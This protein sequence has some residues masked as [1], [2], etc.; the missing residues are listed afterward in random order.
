MRTSKYPLLPLLQLR[1]R[2]VDQAAHGL[3]E[4]V[5]VRAAAEVRLR[6]A[7]AAEV[8]ARCAAQT[9]RE[10]EREA[11][12]SGALSAADLARTHAWEARV[13]QE[14]ENLEKQTRGSEASAVAAQSRENAA[15]VDVAQRQAAAQVIGS[16]QEKWRSARDH[17]AEA[18]E[19]DDAADAWRPRG[20]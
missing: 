13:A 11:L 16:D 10:D 6:A 9:V 5:G 1:E 7:E 17:A 4:A 2:Q 14:R 3:A 20:T 19:E 8:D 18:H 12:N 15:R